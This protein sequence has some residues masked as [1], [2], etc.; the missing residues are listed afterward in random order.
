M[1]AWFSTTRGTRGYALIERP[2][3]PA[4][5]VRTARQEA[6]RWASRVKLELDLGDRP[7]ADMWLDG[8]EHDGY[9]FVPLRTGQEFTE[10][11]RSMRNCV[12]SYGYGVAHNRSR[13][14]SVR[15]QGERVATLEL[16]LRGGDPL[17]NIVQLCGAGDWEVS[18]ETAWAARRWLN[19]H[20][21]MRIDTN[22]LRWGDTPLD[23]SSWIR[24]WRP[25]WVAKRRLPDWL[26][27]L[28][29][30]AEVVVRA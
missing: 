11:A 26:P 13:L 3:D 18:R 22:W 10:E 12:E 30:G 6:E 4:M 7:L 8:G 28:A 15:Y 20:D 14:W 1:F 9:H 23:R 19:Q 2:W 16:G 21:L 17:V 25:Y 5:H 24:L 29:Q 27:L